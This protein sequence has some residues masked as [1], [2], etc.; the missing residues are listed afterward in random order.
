LK[1]FDSKGNSGTEITIRKTY[2]QD[3]RN[4]ATAQ[5]QEGRLF[6]ELLKDLVEN[7]EEHMRT[8]SGRPSIPLKEALFC[9]I[10]K[11]YSMQSSRRAYS[12]YLDAERKEQIGKAPRY[13]VINITLNRFAPKVDISNL[14]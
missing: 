2:S 3:W 6:R 12:L 13:N 14:F 7:V 10:E 11:V 5:N 1:W 8:G 4:Y 9:S